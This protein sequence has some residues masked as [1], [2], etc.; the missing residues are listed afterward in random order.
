MISNKSIRAQARTVLSGNIFSRNWLMA[1]LICLIHTFALK[2]LDGFAGIGTLLLFSFFAYGYACVFLP[3]IRGK[4]ENV[5]PPAFIGG[6]EQIGGLIVLS[7]MTNLFVILWSLLFFIPGIVKSYAYAMAPYIKYDHPEY[8]WKR[9]LDESRSMMRGYKWKLF[10]L[11]LSFIGWNIVGM[12][13]FF[14]GI[15][16]VTPYNTA[17]RVCF[18]NELK[19]V[20]ES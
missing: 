19:G 2:I 14:V 17:A 11:D 7:L 4:K 1:L 18:Y 3:I 8:G 9:C 12:L 15:Y 10:C 20:S 16:W 6:T 13:C 5:E